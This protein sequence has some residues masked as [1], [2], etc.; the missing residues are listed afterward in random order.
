MMKL[1]T[2]KLKKGD[3]GTATSGQRNP[4]GRCEKDRRQRKLRER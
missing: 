4:A 1:F 3:P 2:R